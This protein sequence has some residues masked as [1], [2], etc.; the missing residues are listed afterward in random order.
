M[1]P[2]TPQ[3]CSQILPKNVPKYPQKCSQIPPKNVF[4]YPYNGGPNIEKQIWNQMLYF[5]IVWHVTCFIVHGNTSEYFLHFV[6]LTLKKRKAA[7]QLVLFKQLIFLHQVYL[8]PMP[9][10]LIECSAVECTEQN[11]NNQSLTQVSQLYVHISFCLKVMKSWLN[12]LTDRHGHVICM[13]QW[14]FITG[15]VLFHSHPKTPKMT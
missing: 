9:S 4:K 7:K 5:W 8:Q 3:K 14:V 10:W 12:L 15:S 2:N 1:F 13:P 6:M 11:V